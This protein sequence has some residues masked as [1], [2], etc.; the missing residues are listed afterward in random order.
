MFVT[1]WRSNDFFIVRMKRR[2]LTTMNKPPNWAAYF[3]LGNLKQ[4]IFVEGASPSCGRS[5]SLR[6][7][8]KDLP[9]PFLPRKST[10]LPFNNFRQKDQASKPGLLMIS[11]SHPYYFFSNCDCFMWWEI[12][13][14]IGS[15]ESELLSTSYSLM[16]RRRTG[17]A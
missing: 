10:H 13:S 5:E 4:L 16:F 8:R 14:M 1:L 17:H 2:H 6:T 7:M 12:F 15:M 3:F 9:C 11:L